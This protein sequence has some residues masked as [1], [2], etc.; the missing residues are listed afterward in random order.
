MTKAETE[1]KTETKIRCYGC[2]R[3][4]LVRSMSI[5]LSQRAYFC[6]RCVPRS[7]CHK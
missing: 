2:M 3:L 4:R 1:T 6:A 7:W 5:R